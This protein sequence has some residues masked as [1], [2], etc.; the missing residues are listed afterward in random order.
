MDVWK[1]DIVLGATPSKLSQVLGQVGKKG[2]IYLSVR[3]LF[4]LQQQIQRKHETDGPNAAAR[5]LLDCIRP[6]PGFFDALLKVMDYEELKLQEFKCKFL[7]MRG[8]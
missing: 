2:S 6:K 5:L 8:R 1:C 4:C 3:Y 7:D